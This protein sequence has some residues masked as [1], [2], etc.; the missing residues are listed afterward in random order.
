MAEHFLEEEE[1]ETQ[2]NGKILIRIIKQAKSHW[3]WVLG[4]IMMI[5][6]VSLLDSY[7]TYLSKRIVDEGILAGNPG[8]LKSIITQYGGLILLQAIG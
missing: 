7:F 3:Q 4:F 6:L 1:F 5:T 8:A 2:F